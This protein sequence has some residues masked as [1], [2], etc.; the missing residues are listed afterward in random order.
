MSIHA[1]SLCAFTLGLMQYVSG[2]TGNI[3]YKR[4][5]IRLPHCIL[6][7]WIQPVIHLSPFE[8][9]MQAPEIRQCVLVFHCECGKMNR[10]IQH[11][12]MHYQKNEMGFL[13]MRILISCDIRFLSGRCSLAFAIFISFYPTP[14]SSIFP[15]DCVNKNLP[16]D[17]HSHSLSLSIP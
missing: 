15:F 7:P 3:L 5:T 11:T 8:I 1:L 14:N 4:E 13:W 16:F 2:K 12:L 6:D 9:E 17:S 10:K